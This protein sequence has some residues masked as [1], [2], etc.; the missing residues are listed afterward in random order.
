MR[1]CAFGAC[2][3]SHHNVATWLLCLLPARLPLT[4]TLSLMLQIDPPCARRS[5]RAQFLACREAWH[6]ELVAELDD[7]GS[8]Y[9]YLKRLT[10]VHRLHLFD[11]VMQYRAIFSDHSSAQ[12]RPLLGSEGRAGSCMTWVM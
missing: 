10:D 11:V 2:R 3:K 9:D 1:I 6:A 4:L 5:C 8:P 7:S 12:V